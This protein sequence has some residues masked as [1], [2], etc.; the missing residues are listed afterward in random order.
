MRAVLRSLAVLAAVAL[1]EAAAALPARGP[2][3]PRRPG[4]GAHEPVPAPAPAPTEASPDAA[5]AASGDECRAELER[6][7]VAYE[8][9]PAIANGDCGAA[10]PLLVWRV[11]EGVALSPPAT[12]TCPVAR[13]VARWVGEVVVPEAQRRLDAPVSSLAIGTSYECRNENRRGGGKRSEHAYAGALDVMAFA[14]GPGRSLPVG[15]TA[16]GTPEGAFI[17]AAREGACRH[18]TT[19]LGPG[20]DPQHA[21]HLHLDLRARKAGYRICQ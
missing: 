18:F 4:L 16:P 12:L 17:A 11:A 3:P 1:A 10:R 7:G 15:T 13:A 21:T 14:L 2:L 6:L 9:A 8:V 19:V 5:A 20:S